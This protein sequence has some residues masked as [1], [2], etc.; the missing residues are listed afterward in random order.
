MATRNREGRKSVSISKD[1]EINVD[2][3]LDGD[4]EK[5]K[6]SYQT[7]L[8]KYPFYVN[9]TQSAIISSSSVVVSQLLAGNSKIDWSEVR[10]VAFIGAFWITPVLLI[11]YSKL[12]RLPLGVMGKLALDQLIFSPLFTVTIISLRLIVL[13]RVPYAD[14]TSVLGQTVPKAVLSSWTFWVPAR[15]FTLLIVPAHLHLLAGNIFSFIWNII[16]SMLLNA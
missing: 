6:S 3:D 9:S 7:L 13:G 11:F 15:G 1:D 4:V 10:T 14:F 8:M 5:K 16:L 2:L 12:H